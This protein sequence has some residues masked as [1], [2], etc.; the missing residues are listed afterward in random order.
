ME[1]A[2]RASDSPR[3]GVIARSSSHP[4]AGGVSPAHFDSIEGRTDLAL[5]LGR[6][7]SWE[8]SA[9]TQSV[10]WSAPVQTALGH[11]PT[12]SYFRFPRS[13]DTE[14]MP[15]S[16]D[17]VEDLGAALLE[18]LLTII[19]GGAPWGWDAAP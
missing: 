12:T 8:Y 9:A 1:G 11:Q 4:A 2:R 17:M 10:D 5:S 18:P 7:V 14:S 6:M 13:D 15:G 3:R 19:R 16:R